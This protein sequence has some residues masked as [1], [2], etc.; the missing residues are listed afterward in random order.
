MKRKVRVTPP[1]SNPFA[2]NPMSTWMAQVGGAQPTQDQ[3]IV[4]VA[5]E[6]LTQ[7]YSDEDAKQMLASQGFP[8]AKVTEII[9]ALSAYVEEQTDLQEANYL[10]DTAAQE[11]ILAEQ[12]AAEQAAQEQEATSQMYYAEDTDPGY[13][14]EDYAM[15]DILM[16]FG[17][18]VPSKKEFVKRQLK[19]KKKQE[20][21]IDEQPVKADDTLQEKRPLQN[22]IAKVSEKAQQ[23]SEEEEMENMYDSMF[24]NI[25]E[26]EMPEAQFG[27]ARN[28]RRTQRRMNRMIRQVPAGFYN[29]QQQF[30]PPQM[31]MITM[32][33]MYP[34]AYG[35][36]QMFGQ[37]IQ[38]ANI[39][40][41]RTGLF[42]RPKEYTINF[43]NTP[44]AQINP[45]EVIEQEVKNTEETQKEIQEKEKEKET[46]TSSKEN[47]KVQEELV[48]ADQINVVG[49]KGSGTKSTATT[50]AKST[51]KVPGSTGSSKPQAKPQQSFSDW[52]NSPELKEVVKQSLDPQ[53]YSPNDPLKAVTVKPKVSDIQRAVEINRMKAQIEANKR[54]AQSSQKSFLDEWADNILTSRGK[55][56]DPI[57]GDLTEGSMQYGGFADMSNPD[58]YKFIYGGND[59]SF[60][61]YMDESFRSNSKDVTDPYFAYGGN[62]PKAQG[63]YWTGKGEDAVWNEGI[64]PRD[65]GELT[66]VSKNKT[67]YNNAKSKGVNVGDYREGIDYSKIG[68]GTQRAAY[69]QGY[70][71]PQVGAM[72]PPVFGGRRS[73]GMGLFG[74]NKSISYAG[75][76]AQQRGL[77]Y[78]PA[79]GK[80][81]A[82]INNPQIQSIDVR[83]SGLF[84]QPKKYTIN[85]TGTTPGGGFGSFDKA[86]RD[87]LTAQSPDTKK[88]SGLFNTSDEKESRLEGMYRRL[89]E[90]GFSTPDGTGGKSSSI[91]YDKND[92]AYKKIYG[93]YPGEGPQV[94]LSKELAFQTPTPSEDEQY[95]PIPDFASMQGSMLPTRRATVLDQFIG[96]E[97][98]ASQMYSSGQ[99][100]AQEPMALEPG[101]EGPMTEEDM[102]YQQEQDAEAQAFEQQR[103]QDLMGYDMGILGVPT[104]A[105]NYLAES[106]NE[107]AM[108][109][110]AFE[111]ERM[112]MQ[113]PEYFNEGLY[114]RPLDFESLDYTQQP[115]EIT[116]PESVSQ[117]PIVRN[118]QNQY[119]RRRQEVQKQPSKPIAKQNVSPVSPKEKALEE[120]EKTLEQVER[121]RFA[122]MSPAEKLK[123]GYDQASSRIMQSPEVRSKMYSQKFKKDIGQTGLKE[124]GNYGSEEALFKAF[125]TNP[126]LGQKLWYE[127][128]NPAEN[129]AR[130]EL[131]RKYERWLSSQR[132]R[133]TGGES[134]IP[135]AQTMG[136]FNTTTPFSTANKAVMPSAQSMMTN[137]FAMGADYENPFTG[138]SPALRM[139]TDGKY[140]NEGVLTDADLAALN[141]QNMS[142]DYKTKNMYNVD[143]ED[144][145]NKF[146]TGANMGLSMFGE[147]GDVG[148]NQMAN[149]NLTAGNVYN[150]R[151][152]LDR[153]DYNQWG[154]FRPDNLG[155]KDEGQTT[156]AQKGG[157]MYKQ[158]GTHYM[159]A[160]QIAQFL[161]EGGEIEFI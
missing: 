148:I 120:R 64:D 78:D 112:Q 18:K 10:E 160:K 136:Q 38:M 46:T 81:I 132:T 104:S 3:Q 82:G 147:I 71:N 121:D 55:G 69:N 99:P 131:Y 125:Q 41:R 130:R 68:Q 79:T 86:R 24:G 122:Q 61:P 33:G 2:S 91:G 139:G 35:M 117:R 156:R 65:A 57:F 98:I 143:F 142:V 123:Y 14:E 32:P 54:K 25:E 29:A 106:A 28:P 27:W 16:Q 44:P 37:G 67:N 101:Q 145:V 45:R 49:S 22:F 47:E 153:G 17:G 92:E 6:L 93:H 20:G 152:D 127:S 128:P 89:T 77:P 149:E 56:V 111:L 94:D 53:V 115:G 119:N 19:L 36:D 129:Q 102:L 96:R 159:S 50:K 7:G 157:A 72:Y 76:W 1:V 90:K 109:R 40:V 124:F 134:Y 60:M 70:Y 63:G 73:R 144:L 48:K 133:Q 80:P 150:H 118:A 42:G 137:P 85:Y 103:Q 138:A 151:N 155:F 146:N 59:P 39:D 126:S 52:W 58:L 84:G 13:A 100:F 30:L 113:N 107:N 154:V 31:N 95:A 116:T 43:A 66:N 62:I 97:P 9:D 15:Q 4:A 140:V 108:D 12:A 110:Q 11:E 158:G 83:K 5:T 51:S 141:Q 8:V 88:K 105:D 34:Q 135:M 26:S 75:S 114:N 23:K 87:A 161:A 74:P 21:G